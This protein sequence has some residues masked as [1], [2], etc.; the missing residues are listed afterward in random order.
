MSKVTG[1]MAVIMGAF[2]SI[3]SFGGQGLLATDVRGVAPVNV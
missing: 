1:R 3:K 2:Y